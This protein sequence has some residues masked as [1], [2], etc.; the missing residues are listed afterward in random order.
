[1]TRQRLFNFLAPVLFAV[2]FGFVVQLT[3]GPPWA[4]IMTMII[5]VTVLNVGM[6]P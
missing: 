6:R 2:A 3:G 1:M 4:G 5:L